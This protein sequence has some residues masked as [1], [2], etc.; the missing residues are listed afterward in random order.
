MGLPPL[1]VMCSG[2]R[3]R[4]RPAVAAAAG[5]HRRIHGNGGRIHGGVAQIHIPS[6]SLY[7]DLAAG[8][9]AGELGYVRR[10]R[11]VA[12][13]SRLRRGGP[14]SKAADLT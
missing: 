6:L 7:L 9:A 8:G 10:R 11:V 14:G 13:G 2:V 5:W 4:A 1:V 3:D 12:H